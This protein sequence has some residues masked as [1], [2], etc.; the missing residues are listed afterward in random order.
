MYWIASYIL[1]LKDVNQSLLLSIFYNIFG[2]LFLTQKN[3]LKIRWCFYSKV[4]APPRPSTGKKPM[5]IFWNFRCC[6]VHIMLIKMLLLSSSSNVSF[7]DYM[8]KCVYLLPASHIVSSVNVWCHKS[9]ACF[10]LC[11]WFYYKYIQPKIT[12]QDGLAKHFPTVRLYLNVTLRKWTFV[13]T[14]RHIL[15]EWRR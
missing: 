5:W 4:P 1:L 11:H 9:I 12:K 15:S 2:V 14:S 7:Y 3:H 13:D 8:H 10:V 6:P